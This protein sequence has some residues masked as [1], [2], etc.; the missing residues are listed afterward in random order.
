MDVEKRAL[1]VAAVTIKGCIVLDWLIRR[2]HTRSRGLVGLVDEGFPAPRQAVTVETRVIETIQNLLARSGRSVPVTAATRLYADGLGLD[3]L[4]AAELST[5]L[6]MAF[7]R[8]PYSEG[9]I[10]R[11]VAEI[12]RYYDPSAGSR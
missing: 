8:D 4:G 11:S 3:S 7:G 10:P 5:M 1:R 12:V 2:R 6:E 9:L